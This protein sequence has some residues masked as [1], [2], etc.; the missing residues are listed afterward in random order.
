MA[1]GIKKRNQLRK[2]GVRKTKSP[3]QSAADD[4]KSG[5]TDESDD[6]TSCEEQ[7][8]PTINPLELYTYSDSPLQED[9]DSDEFWLSA[10]A[11]QLYG[12]VLVALLLRRVCLLYGIHCVVLLRLHKIL[13]AWFQFFRNDPPTVETA[14]NIRRVVRIFLRNGEKVLSGNYRRQVIAAYLL[15]ACTAPGES[16]ISYLIRYKM[17]VMNTQWIQELESYMERHHGYEEEH[18][19]RSLLFG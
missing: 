16:Y 15:H 8:E 1:D 18:S 19:D 14:R 2:R 7:S 11:F 3:N 6:S 13:S 12:V 4:V 17:H 9:S 10:T 5:V